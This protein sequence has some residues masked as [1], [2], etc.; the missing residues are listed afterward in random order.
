MIAGLH[1]REF[2]K[3]GFIR[4]GFEL[5]PAIIV[6]AFPRCM[7]HSFLSLNRRGISEEYTN[8]LKPARNDHPV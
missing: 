8:K 4:I 7:N 2:D 6:C 5:S 3:R 1:S